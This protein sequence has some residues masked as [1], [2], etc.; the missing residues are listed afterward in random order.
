M[1]LHVF[2]PENDLALACFDPHFIPPRS[3]RDL[4]ADLSALPAWWACQGDAVWVSSVDDARRWAACTGGLCPPVEWVDGHCLPECSAVEPWGWSP[5]LVERLRRGG[6]SPE[7]LPGG[8]TLRRY[9]E[10]SGRR[11]AVELLSFLRGSGSWLGRRWGDRLCGEAFYCTSSDEVIREMAG[12][13]AVL[14][15]APWSGSGKGL[16]LAAAGYVPQVSGWCD[17]VLREQGGVVVEPIYNK[18][19]DFACEFRADGKGHVCPEG[20]SVFLTNRLGAYAG[21]WGAS[22]PVK[23]QWLAAYIPPDLVLVL[24]NELGRALAVR[25]P[26]YR[27]PLGV[28]MMLCRMPGREDLCLHP[29]VEVN[30]RRTMGGGGHEDG[31]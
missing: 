30:L 18:V 21:S 8:E 6:L 20:L 28:D 15:K 31:A 9:R 2:N 29:C 4:S 16:R 13:P 11:H 19:W 27:G 22:E 25:F 14:L 1:T 23:A 12:R 10:A 17:R 7:L 5:L 26:D 24:G 3:A